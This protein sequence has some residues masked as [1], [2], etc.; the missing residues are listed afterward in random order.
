M[1]DPLLAACDVVVA[2]DRGAFRRAV[3]GDLVRQHV[4]VRAA[5][6]VYGALGAGWP[7]TL[8]VAAYG[9]ASFVSAALPRTRRPVVAVA[10]YANER[11]QIDDVARWIGGDLVARSDLGPRAAASPRSWTALARALASPER[12]GSFLRVVRRYDRGDFLTA[13][14]AASTAG[15]YLR[16]E[17]ELPE[18]GARAVLV[19]SDSN[20]Y[21]MA[22]I[23]AARRHGAKT[24][25]VNHGHVPDGPPRLDFDLSLLDGPALLDVYRRSAGASGRVV[26]KGVEGEYRRLDTKALRSGAP[27]RLG[28]F[29]SL[30]VD[31]EA[32]GRRF[33][34]LQRALRP[35]RVLL[36][37]H[38]NDVIRDRRALAHVGAWANLDVSLGERVLTHDAARCDLVLVGNSSCHLTV[39]KY[40]VPS[41]YVRDLDIVPH[42][43]YGFLRQRIV[44]AFDH[45][46]DVDVARIADFYEDADWVRRFRE[47][48]ATYGE[49]PEEVHRRVA[50][51]VREVVG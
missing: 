35:A 50:R 39:L 8:F 31:W 45:P 2:K 43:F 34:E 47:L 32:F 25:Y 28:I 13:C 51:A 41:A 38:P 9:L 19:S 24:L 37:L 27:L 7:R 22:L 26:F 48:D 20:P 11:R 4:S 21:A 12:L 14:R 18:T 1:S 33:A 10:A 15:Y 44:P 46:D 3:F 30:I 42:D 23:A 17:R 16:F 6:A 36:R 49:D 29:T 40:G 5:R